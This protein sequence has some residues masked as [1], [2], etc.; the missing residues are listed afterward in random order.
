[1]SAVAGSRKRV[2]LA[3]VRPTVD[4][5]HK[6]SKGV[7]SLALGYVAAAARLDGHDVTLVDGQLYGHSPADTARELLDLNP[8]VAGFTVTVNHFPPMLQETLR[9]L[10]AGG[11]AGVVLVGGHAVSFFPERIVCEVPEV[12][13]V[14]SG[15]GEVAIREILQAI[16]DGGDWRRVAGVTAR[17][18]DGEVAKRVPRRL[19]RLDALPWPARDLMPDVIRLDAIPAMATSRG[20]YARC[21]FCS[22]PRF[23]GLEKG[24]SLA[25]GAWLARSAEDVANEVARLVDRYGVEELLI[26][27]DEFFGGNDA[28]HARALE[29]GDRM[30]RLDLGV[31]FAISCR[32]ENV[33][34]RVMAALRAGGLN[35]VFIGVES[36]SEE[37]LRFYAKNHTVDQNT[38]A[39]RQVKAMGMTVQC[40]FMMFTPQSTLSTVRQNIEFLK[41]I[42]ECKPVTLNSTVDPHFGAPLVRRMDR[43]GVLDDNGLQLSTRLVDPRVRTVKEVAQRATDA[44]IPFMNFL[45]A[46]RSS[47]TW[48]WR[49]PVPGRQPA[50]EQLLDGY[51]SA[52]HQAFAAVV[53]EAVAQ[54]EGGATEAETLATVDAALATVAPRLDIGKGLVVRQLEATEGDIRYW[55]HAD[56]LA[57]RKGVSV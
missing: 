16:A 12:D 28:G 10:R 37:D 36:G 32:A 40:G 20:C 3:M 34:E 19:H 46:T 5:T 2:S 43:D 13:G 35:H 23:Y 25:S 22:V 54:L 57:H 14:L 6:F 56:L 9:L 26:V 50:Q 33:D 29:F 11:Y 55:S 27:D 53:D 15:E 21:S 41:D 47:I 30:A 18:D 7:E 45:A 17:D 49:R 44:Y 4:V 51:E 24:K 42:D 8:D 52:V 39:V 1:M 38:R 31:R 48:E